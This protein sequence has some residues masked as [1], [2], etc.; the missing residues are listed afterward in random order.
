MVDIDAVGGH[1]EGGEGV[2]LDGE[3]LGVSGNPGV[4][5][6]ELGHPNSVPLGSPSPEHTTELVLR[7]TICWLA[8]WAVRHGC[9]GLILLG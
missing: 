9:Q 1:A 5:D 7:D 4:P 6:L 8:G 3:V 2:A